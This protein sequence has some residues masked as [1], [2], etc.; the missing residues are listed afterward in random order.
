MTANGSEDVQSALFTTAIRL[1][2]YTRVADTNSST[3][4]ET[5]T[6]IEIIDE[7]TYSSYVY[8]K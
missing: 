8:I 4:P 1:L 6:R 7:F 2:L 3:P 5:V